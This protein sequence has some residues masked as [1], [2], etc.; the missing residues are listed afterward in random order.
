MPVIFNTGIGNYFC[1]RFQT[2]K[3]YISAMSVHYIG[4]MK[5]NKVCQECGSKNIILITSK[6]SF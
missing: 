5:K 1:F 6:R 3:G 4:T 2:T